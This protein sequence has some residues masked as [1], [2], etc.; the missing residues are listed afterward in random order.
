MLIAVG[1]E[2][3]QLDTMLLKAAETLEDKTQARLKK[4]LTLI[5][6]I[7]ILGLGALIAVVIVAI[8]LAM[9]GLNDLVF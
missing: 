7:M 9:L 4:A 3:G 8:L 2:S 6:P 5:E 1:E